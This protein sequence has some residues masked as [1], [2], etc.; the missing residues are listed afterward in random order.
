MWVTFFVFMCQ[1]C[2]PQIGQ[3]IIMIGF[4]VKYKILAVARGDILDE[5]PNRM[6]SRWQYG[7]Y[8][9][10]KPNCED[11]WDIRDEV[12][13]SELYIEVTY[14]VA[15]N[16]KVTVLDCLGNKIKPIV[17]RDSI[18]GLV[19]E[20]VICR[21]SLLIFAMNTDDGSV[22]GR[23]INVVEENGCAVL[24]RKRILHKKARRSP[25]GDF[26]PYSVS[27]LKNSFSKV[28]G[29]TLIDT[30]NDANIDNL[31]LKHNGDPIE[32]KRAIVEAN[33]KNRVVL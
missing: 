12:K 5:V 4:D 2:C 29:R 26:L 22:S 10:E 23:K 6:L 8:L 25:S 20:S 15:S 19:Y 28:F 30:C 13:K 11:T 17:D 9:T 27:I 24:R 14:P 32:A 18:P 21:G 33:G 7:I 1:E 31:M 16:I 3:L